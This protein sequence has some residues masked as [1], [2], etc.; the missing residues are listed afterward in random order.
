MRLAVNPTRAIR[1]HEANIEPPAVG[2]AMKWTRL[3]CS[4]TEAGFGEGDPQREGTTRYPLTIDAMACA[5]QL[6]NFGHVVADFAALAAAGQ[7]KLHRCLLFDPEHD[8]RGGRPLILVQAAVNNHVS[9]R[10]AGQFG[11]GWRL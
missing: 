9:G 2:R 6:R 7:R 8:G 4:E 3:A 11:Q 10:R 5:D 1:A